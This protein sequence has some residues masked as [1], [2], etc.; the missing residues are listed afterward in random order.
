MISRGS[1]FTDDE[2]QLTE[3]KLNQLYVGL[4]KYSFFLAQN[5]CEADDLVQ[6]TVLKAIQ[7][8]GVSELN[9][10]LL[11]K[12]AYHQWI[13]VIRKRKNEVLGV[14]EEEL[15]KD[16]PQHDELLDTVKL[17]LNKLTPKQA[18]ILVMK[19]AFRFQIVEIADLMDTTEMAVKSLLHRAKKRLQ[20]ESSLRMI[21][22]YLSIE[23][24]EMLSTTLYKALQAEDPTVLIDCITR[25]PSLVQ[26]PQL[27]KQKQS[28]SPLNLS[29]I[30]A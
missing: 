19:E 24:R 12:I 9:A 13:D 29:C 1:L 15:V 22:D 16:T 17:L 26:T 21:D 6:E 28:G 20:K 8:Y 3:E 4:Q 5:K 2:I 14:L 23:E 7:Y 18:V 25:I 27:V 30:A 10:A 11:K